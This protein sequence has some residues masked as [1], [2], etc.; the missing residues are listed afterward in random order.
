MEREHKGVQ[1]VSERERERA[2]CESFGMYGAGVYIYGMGLCVCG[3]GVNISCMGVC[4]CG[5]GLRYV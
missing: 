1:G 3:A 4:V 2:K 5:V